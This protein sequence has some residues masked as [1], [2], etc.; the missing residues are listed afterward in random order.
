M[1]VLRRVQ[2]ALAKRG[3]ALKTG[4]ECEF[5]LLDRGG[6]ALSDPMDTQPKPCYDAHALMRRY[7][8]ISL[9]SEDMERMGWGPYQVEQQ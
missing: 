2:Q 7:D 8:L 6:A 3:L 5:F 9:V 1:Q 4:V